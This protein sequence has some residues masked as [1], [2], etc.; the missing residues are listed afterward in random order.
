M[1]HQEYFNYNL[2]E[3]KDSSNFFVNSTNAES[4]N[5]IMNN[6]KIKDAIT[7]YGAEL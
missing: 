2:K 7:I 6:N 1:T 3:I 5:I 4:Y